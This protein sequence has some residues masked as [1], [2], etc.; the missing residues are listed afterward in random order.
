MKK[1]HILNHALTFAF[2]LNCFSPFSENVRIFI[3]PMKYNIFIVFYHEIQYNI[4]ILSFNAMC[5]D[6]KS[7]SFLSAHVVDAQ[8]IQFNSKHPDG[9]ITLFG[10]NLIRV[11]VCRYYYTYR[12]YCLI[13]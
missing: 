3:Y 2:K 8:Q 13:D 7:H 5:I 4:V 12:W 1:L 9:Q 6:I 11:R 10:D